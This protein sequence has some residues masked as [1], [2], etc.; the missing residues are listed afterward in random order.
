M[1][2]QG[3][4]ATRPD[5]LMIVS[6]EHNAS[7]TGCYGDP[8]V[9]T[10]SIDRLAAEG[11]L[12]ERAYCP[13]P[14]CAPSRQSFKTGVY[15]HQIE[16]WGNS[17]TLASDVPTFAHALGIAGY[18][19]VLDG[20]AHWH[21]PDQRHGFEHRLVG[22]ISESYWGTPY[23]RWVKVGDATYLVDANA[24]RLSVTFFTGPGGSQYQEYDRVVLKAALRFL[25]N[26]S[27]QPDRRPFCLLVGF[28]SPHYYT[29]C[30]PALFDLY[31]GRVA[32]PP[33]PDDHPKSLHPYNRRVVASMD[34][35]SVPVED[36]KRARAGYYGLITFTDRMVGRLLD[37]LEQ[38][39]LKDNTLVLYFSDH[40]D[41]AGE[42]GMWWKHT[43]YEGASRVPLI[44]S[45]PAR[46]PG[47][48][49]VKE[50]V[51][52]VDLFPSLCDWTGAPRPQG[53]VGRSLDP[54]MRGKQGDRERA[55]FSELYLHS[56]SD[57][58]VARMVRKGPWKY[59]YY[60]GEPA[61]LFNLEEDPAEFRNLARAPMYKD[62]G[63]ELETLALEH[64][65]P[66]EILPK[67]RED[68][69]RRAYLR[70]W[71]DAANPA[72]PDLWDGIKPPFPDQWR[73]DAL[74]IPQYAAWLEEREAGNVGF[75][76]LAR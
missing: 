63:K 64:W 25:K 10:P 30:P 17:A 42:H 54:L 1:D 5:I 50:L 34:W 66:E 69:E 51:S 18:E 38:R 36:V 23:D 15:P 22:D 74:S 20:R 27:E 61:E 12:F 37:A 75:R 26:R 44:V 16:C 24:P 41:M 39:A 14:A 13:Y 3:G 58:V 65:D 72:D 33:L 21:G 76:R 48:V 28:M 43:F 62:V 29:T 11:A 53:L 52:L 60:Y 19:V 7:I 67:L 71:T 40:G 55:V 49:R 46:F 32:G 35:E 31:E 4:G 56:P 6:D 70:Q 8:I 47:G 2:A 73:E 9:R 57:P 45:W 59:N 68:R